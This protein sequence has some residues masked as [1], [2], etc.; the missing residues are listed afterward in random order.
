MNGNGPAD[1]R[2]EAAA[3]ETAAI[4]IL[5]TDAAL[6]VRTWDGWLARATGVDA[7]EARGRDLLDLIPDLSARGLLACFERVLHHGG[8]EVLAPALHR[9]LIA[10]PPLTSSSFFPV[11]QQR[12]TIGP[13]CQEG[14]IVGTIVAI[15]DVTARLERERHWAA[16]LADPDAEV[17]LRAA[18]WLSRQETLGD[19]G[20]L[21]ATIGDED[22]R[23]RRAAVQAL[24]RRHT[25]DVIAAVLQALRDD[26]RHFS[27][28]S[29]AMALL[30][31]GDVDV[32]EPLVDL[33]R[34]PDV[35]LRLQAVLLLGE[36]NDARGVEPLVG[37]LG[38]PDDNV[39]FHA[40]EALGVLK[41]SA[42]VE[43]LTAFAESGDF[44]L[45]FPA[46]EA[47]SRIGDPSVAPRLVPLLAHDLLRG[48]AAEVLGRLGDED[49]VPPLTRLLNDATAPTEV[50]ADALARVF[51]RYD[52]R[53]ADGEHIAE[54]VRLAI[55]PV[56]MQN[57]LDAVPRA[58][59]DDLRAIATVLG[60][61]DAPAVDRAVTRL[62][63][64]PVV[65]GR[66]VEYLVRHGERV[67]ELLIDQ[68]RAEDLDTRQAAV[69]G[70][71]RI[72]D[73]RAT[74][75]LVQMLDRDSAL[76]LVVA[77][78]LARLGDARAFEPLMRFVDHPD[79]AARQAVIAALN[80]IG[81]PRMASAVAPLLRHRNPIVRESAVRI[82]GYFGYP[83]CADA[84][85]A[86]CEDAAPGVRL[87]ALEHLPF[88]DDLRVLR[89]LRQ[90]LSDADPAVRS[91]AVQALGR[92]DHAD[93]ATSLVDM[94][95]DPDAW[96]RYFSARA[97]G[98]RRIDAGIDRLTQLA[99]EDP[100]GHVRLAAIDA[101]G[102]I[103]DP[104]A[105]PVLA[106]LADADEPERAAA[107]I[108]ALG[109]IGD[110]EALRPL[111][112]M[113]RSVHEDR[114]VAAAEAVALVGGPVA[115][116]LLAWSAGA[117][118]SPMVAAAALEGLGR[119]AAE[120]PTASAAVQALIGLSADQPRRET[121]V[122]VLG[123]LAASL[124]GDVARGLRDPRA[125]VRAATV[126]ALGGMR[127]PEATRALESAL[128]DSAVDV[129]L[130]ALAELRRLGA[131]GL[132]RRL[133]QIAR[134]DPDHAVRRAAL[135]TVE[136]GAGR[137]PGGAG[138][139]R[140]DG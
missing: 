32:V 138:A 75:A 2:R 53:Y 16:E 98:A 41:A 52:R 90:A 49:V 129:R 131:R 139:A 86:C 135:A 74:P 94:L 67:L 3:P 34:S 81:H 44:F 10:C 13:L 104:L 134:T 47:L 112:T 92:F 126:Q 7:E 65:G 82:A 68:L 83:T 42:A 77:G 78:A 125:A 124:T 45:A 30:A 63:G 66:A 56:G 93:V 100:A 29:S 95:D 31:A 38:D 132:E 43:P 18:S 50:V 76:T 73:K 57:L 12:V 1:D 23:V 22:W 11:M 33:L 119:L 79:P 108:R 70:L 122:A 84:L 106:A 96:V 123:N 51:Q 17:R 64:Q 128:D 59:G 24:R 5:T 9:Y 117:D 113:L 102:E 4:G 40:I 39:R 26:H 28:L 137:G 46:L 89:V 99:L 61:L 118:E 121:V 107:A 120:K 140:R 6:V 71:G 88:L 27:V 60:W 20:P 136:R 14:R 105:V 58:D 103:G 69:V 111:Q 54:L 36:Q 35:D 101:L 115:V 110:D 8:V 55:A 127:R 130:A 97:S 48:A 133:V 19:P 25:T 114:R 109:A 62:L 21:M 116:D 72:G 15:E 80:S 87:A 37:L 91:M 85:L